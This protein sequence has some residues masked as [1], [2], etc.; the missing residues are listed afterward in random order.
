M[1]E[2]V[3]YIFFLQ[4]VDDETYSTLTNVVLTNGEKIN[5]TAFCKKFVTAIYGE[6]K[7][8]LMY[9]LRE[10]RQTSEETVSHYA[11]RLRE[12]ASVAYT[13]IAARK[14]NCLLAF[15]R[16]LRDPQLKRKLNE[17]KI[18][19]FE[20]AVEQAKR[21][22]LVDSML[23]DEGP[24]ISSVLKETTYSFRPARQ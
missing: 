6:E 1:D 24:E 21:L 15:L 2:S 13:E 14:E 16:G 22:E 17:A 4:H 9:Q 8:S 12:K 19:S 23:K 11:Y 10:C 18:A 20:E 7:I 3:S 5:P